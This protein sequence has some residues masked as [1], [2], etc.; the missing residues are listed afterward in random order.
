MCP[1][2]G[3]N[4]VINCKY[5]EENLFDIAEGNIETGVKDELERHLES[6]DSCR[7]LVAEFRAVLESP[8]TVPEIEPSVNFLPKLNARLDELEEADKVRTPFAIFA[9]LLRPVAA[10]AM[11]VG[12]VFLGYTYGRVSASATATA[13]EY[14]TIDPMEQYSL[15]ALSPVPE[16]SI[17]DFYLDISDENEGD[18]S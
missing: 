7:N 12:T 18:E 8:D 3:G 2:D 13:A 10:V 9:R 1:V 14:S 17:T 4:E 16:V 11:I 15:D 6:C 5:I